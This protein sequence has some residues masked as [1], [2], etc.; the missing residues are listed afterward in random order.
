MQLAVKPKIWERSV[1]RMK[2]Y[3][4]R[5]EVDKQG[6]HFGDDR[7][8]SRGYMGW[9]NWGGDSGFAWSKKMVGSKQ[10][11]RVS[12]RS[13]TNPRRRRNNSLPPK[14]IGYHCGKRK[15]SDVWNAVRFLGRGENYLGGRVMPPLG[16]GI[17]FATARQDYDGIDPRYGADPHAMTNQEY[18]DRF[19]AWRK[20][21]EEK[22]SAPYC[23]YAPLPY[24]SIVEIDT[25][26]L[27]GRFGFPSEAVAK[28]YKALLKKHS[29]MY[30][31]GLFRRLGIEETHKALKKIG[32][33]GRIGGA[34]VSFEVA[35]FDPSIITDISVE[36]MFDQ[37]YAE[38]YAERQRLADQR[39]AERKAARE[40]RRRRNRDTSKTVEISSW[41]MPLREG[42][43]VQ[44]ILFS[45]KHFDGRQA[46]AWL[47]KH[48]F[49]APK[50]DKTANYMRYRQF[51]PKMFHKDSF[52]T[53]EFKKGLLAVVGIPKKKFVKNPKRRRNR[54]EKDSLGHRG[55]AC[56]RWEREGPTEGCPKGSSRDALVKYRASPR[57]QAAQKRL[58][59]RIER[60]TK[61]YLR[62]EVM[63]ASGTPVFYY[64]IVGV[65]NGKK[66]LKRVSKEVAE[67]VRK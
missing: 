1:N 45:T 19:Y 56:K 66:Y 18:Y 67:S 2:A 41:D 9:L 8:P 12:K 58:F 53:L 13:L 61:G 22:M 21:T 57:G 24:L 65:R 29:A 5:H 10:N 14:L 34:G 51:D 25:S 54:W 7:K 59:K 50:M 20:T 55:A 46:R 30:L 64:Y 23:K 4:T 26:G 15:P 11:P 27:M 42:S 3:F 37:A 17:Y 47:H 52:R 28:K 40:A 48:K 62:K 38:E 63:S 31:E 6:K 36:P 35:V 44:T 60:S 33:T 16:W 43:V 49:K 39:Y 32:I